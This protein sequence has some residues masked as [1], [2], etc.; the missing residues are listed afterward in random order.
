MRCFTFTYDDKKKKNSKTF[1]VKILL[2]ESLSEL[3]TLKWRL[4][5]YS[6]ITRTGPCMEDAAR[7]QKRINHPLLDG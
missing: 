3:P 7:D 4:G 6:E 2:N 1:S 5:F